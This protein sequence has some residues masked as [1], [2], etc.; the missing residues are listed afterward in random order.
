MNVDLDNDSI[1]TFVVLNESDWTD[2][3]KELLL[4]MLKAVKLEDNQFQIIQIPSGSSISCESLIHL[5]SKA[6][7]LAFGITPAD[8]HMNIKASLYQTTQLE[9]A[10]LLFSDSLSALIKSPAL[11]KPL[12]TALQ[13]IFS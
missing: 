6:K 7:I 9:E 8:L 2:Q 11:K 13:T 3:T 5:Q 4:K 1:L 12:W 10:S